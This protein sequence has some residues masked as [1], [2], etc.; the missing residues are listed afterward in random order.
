[1]AKKQLSN[2]SSPLICIALG[3]LLMI[4]RGEMIK[5]AVI[6]AAAF[7]IIMGVIDVIKG[8]TKSGIMNIA[9]G[10]IIYLAFLVLFDIILVIL[11]ILIAAK[12]L[13]D[14][15]EVLKSKKKN[16]L[17]VVFAALT[18]AIGIALAFGDLLGDL[19]WVI[20]LLLVIDGVLGLLGAK[21]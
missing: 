20:G 12:G 2:L 7:F 1:M 16:V 4:F 17:G 18:I 3:A 5:W 10:V 21:K 15:I 6:I 9:L 8:R 14:L 13:I 11:G 19:I